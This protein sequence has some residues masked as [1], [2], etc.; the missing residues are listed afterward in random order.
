MFSSCWWKLEGFEE[1]NQSFYEKQSSVDF[2]KLSNSCYS[3]IETHV[4]D[5]V[6][7]WFDLSNYAAKKELEYAAGFNTSNSAANLDIKIDI[8]Y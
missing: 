6:N 8:S 5:K 1:K 4:R 3:E 2:R 7:K